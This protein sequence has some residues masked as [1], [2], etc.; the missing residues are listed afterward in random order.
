MCYEKGGIVDDFLIYMIEQDHY[1]LVVNAANTEKDYKWLQTQNEN[2]ENVIIEDVSD[3]YA[4]LALQGPLAEKILQKVIE[5]DL[6]EM[7]PFSFENNVKFKDRKSTRLN[8]SHVA[9]SYAVF[10]LK[11][12]K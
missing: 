7:K 8:S 2:N 3:S 4:L 9:I 5:I 12:K 10:C 1:L 11:K 6:S